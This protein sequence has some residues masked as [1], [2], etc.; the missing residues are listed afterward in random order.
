MWAGR[1]RIAASSRTLPTQHQGHATSEKQSTS[2]ST[3][4]YAPRHTTY[5]FILSSQLLIH[6]FGRPFLIFA[7]GTTLGG[8]SLLGHISV[9]LSA[10]L[11]L[12][13]IL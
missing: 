12:V 9:G 6:L 7:R 13:P 1:R 5:F 10:N 11:F 8:T 3:I 4:A 2:S